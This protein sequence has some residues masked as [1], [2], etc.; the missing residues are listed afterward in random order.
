MKK[1]RALGVPVLVLV[2]IAS[3]GPKPDP[4]PMEGEPHRFL[5]LETGRIEQGLARLTG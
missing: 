5:V 4:G 1:L 3:G 2:V